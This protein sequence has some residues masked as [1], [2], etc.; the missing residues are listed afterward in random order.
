MSEQNKR[1]AISVRNQCT[2]ME[3]KM[4]M[5]DVYQLPLVN[6]S[7]SSLLRLFMVPTLAESASLTFRRLS[8][9]EPDRSAA[10]R[11][12]KTILLMGASAGS[13]KTTWINALVNYVYGVDVE[14][15]FRL[16]L[17]DEEGGASIHAHSSQTEEITAYD[18]YYQ[19]GFRIPFSLTVVDTPVCGD[20]GEIDGRDK[21]I[22]SLVGEIFSHPKGIQV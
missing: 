10:G 7:T 20:T 6:H 1:L 22:V 3:T 15:P 18:L 16:K 11:T 13:G 9:G 4:D 8:F 5:M 17:V 21:E 12:S 14:D 2:K 19:D